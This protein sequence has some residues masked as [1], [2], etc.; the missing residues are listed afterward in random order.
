[1]RLMGENR[2][3]GREGSSIR[4]PTS[5]CLNNPETDKDQKQGSIRY[6]I[7][8]P[9]ASD[10]AKMPLAK[11]VYPAAAIYAVKH[12]AQCEYEL[13]GDKLMFTGSTSCTQVSANARRAFLFH[14][15]DADL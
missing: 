10:Q 4:R 7:D 13:L 15:V 2:G 6:D 11:D 9:K 8:A 12:E 5:G 1:M 14:G 3:S